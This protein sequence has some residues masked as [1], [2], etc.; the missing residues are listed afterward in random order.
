MGGR[1]VAG[2]PVGEGAPGGY[3]STTRRAGP[4]TDDRPLMVVS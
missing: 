3:V 4:P 1:P 2:G